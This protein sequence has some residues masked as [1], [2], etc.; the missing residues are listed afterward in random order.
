MRFCAC[1]C[2]RFVHVG[3]GLQ[4]VMLACTGYYCELFEGV[5]RDKLAEVDKGSFEGV[6]LC[7]CVREG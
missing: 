7:A 6:W 2:S 4:V 5:L 1:V 3:C